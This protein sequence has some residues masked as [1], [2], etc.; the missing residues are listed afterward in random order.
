VERI[1]C[2]STITAERFY[3]SLG[4]VARGPMMVALRPGIDF[5]AVAMDLRFA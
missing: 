1:E 4:F 3:A 5:P 2:L